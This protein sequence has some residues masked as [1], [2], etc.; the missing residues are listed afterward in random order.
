[1]SDHCGMEM[2]T[3]DAERPGSGG[4][5]TPPPGHCMCEHCRNVMRIRTSTCPRCGYTE[6]T[7]ITPERD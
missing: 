5:R 3:K 7:N 2:H 4:E 6:E 1:M